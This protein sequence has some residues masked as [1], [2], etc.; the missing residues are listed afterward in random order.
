MNSSVGDK[1]RSL[2]LAAS[3]SQSELA[4][5]LYFSNRTISSWENNLRE[6]SL[7]NLKKIANFFNVSLDYFS[8]GPLLNTPINSKQSFQ[9]IKSKP[10]NIDDRYFYI[11]LTSL[12][13]NILLYLF[14]FDNLFNASLIFTFYWVA[15]LIQTITRYSTINRSKTKKFLVPVGTKVYFSTIL[16]QQQRLRHL[17]INSI[18]YLFLI[19]LSNLFYVGILYMI[20]GIDN[21]ITLIAVMMIFVIFINFYHIFVILKTIKDGLPPPI[22]P[23]TKDKVDIGMNYH[24]IAVSAHYFLIIFLMLLIGSYGFSSFPTQFLLLMLFIGAMKFVLLRLVFLS[25][26]KFYSS[27][28]LIAKES[29][30]EVEQTLS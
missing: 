9:E 21:D 14:P 22:E 15:F 3:L 2:R 29:Q 20:Q 7:E 17:V 27:Y 25:N 4:D 12:F 5:K 18:S 30:S 8:D 28:Q 1:I 23:Y 16:N 26:A 6:V 19:V 10:V 24:R 13:V 11:L